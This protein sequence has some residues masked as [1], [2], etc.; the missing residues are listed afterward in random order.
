MTTTIAILAG[1]QSS[2]MGTDK[3]MLDV[4]GEP[5]LARIAREAKETSPQ[6]SPWKGQ[7]VKVLVVGRETPTDWAVDGV[8]FVVDDE[9]GL[10][11]IGGLAVALSM[12]DGPVL[13]LACDMPRLTRRSI[14]WLVGE[15]ESWAPAWGLAVRNGGQIEPLFS[16][17]Q[18][19]LI[20]MVDE[21]IRHGR[22]SLYGLIEDA[23]FDFVDAPDDVRT[24]LVNVNTVEEWERVKKHV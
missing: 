8:E 1:G 22:R 12:T 15:V 19:T 14:G 7:G 5:L 13:M 21:R 24:E 18:P 10:G 2:R 17:Y 11:P 3:A 16:V 23:S 6:P 4:D 20:P 9:A